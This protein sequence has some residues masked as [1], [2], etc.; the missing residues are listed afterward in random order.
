MRLAVRLWH[1]ADIFVIVVFAGKREPFLGPGALDDF[2]HFGKPFGA[3]AIGNAVGL[4]GAREAAAA[5][6]EEQPATADVIDRGAVFGQAQRLAQRQ[7][8]DAG[9]DLD[10]FG[11]G[12]DCARDRHWYRTDRPLGRHMNLRQPDGVETPTFGGVDLLES[13]RE[14]LGLAL[15]GA[16]LKFV[17]HAE[18]ETH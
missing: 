15:P 16:P 6:A 7:N 5:D 1:D 4:I 13:G 9:T 17:E 12:G 3:L 18:F 11:A 10:V 8:L 2:E 14:G